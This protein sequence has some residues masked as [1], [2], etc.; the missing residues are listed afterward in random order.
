M[1]TGI[2][3]KM[4][5][6]HIDF[7]SYFA[8]AEQQKNLKLRGKPVGV[9]KAEGRTVIIA[10]SVEAKRRGVKTGMPVWE[11]KRLCPEI[12][13]APADFDSYD[14]MTRR[15]ARICRRFSD[16]VELFSLDEVFLDAT[17]TAHLFGGSWKLAL[18]LKK[19]IREELGEWMKVS[20]GIAKN[21]LL[22][23]L[24]SDMEKPDGLVEITDEN[25]DICLG[26][27]SFDQIC[28]IGRRLEERLREIGITQLLQIRLMPQ[29]CL[30][31]S[32]GPHWSKEL[33]RMAWGKDD[34]SVVPGRELGLPKSVSRTYTLRREIFD[35]EE[36]LAVVRNLVEEAAEKLRRARMAGRQFG[37]MIRGRGSSSRVSKMPPSIYSQSDVLLVTRKSYTSD[38]LTV[39][40]ELKRLFEKRRWQAPVRFLGVWISLLAEESA[41]ADCFFPEARRRKLILAAQDRINQRFGNYTLFPASLLRTKII[42][43]EVNGYLGDERIRQKMERSGS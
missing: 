12:I 40:R 23:K 24:A 25:Q 15:F 10:A 30:L 41:L 16:R 3:T 2:N 39:F 34:S 33:V 38:P 11:A 1:F 42:M 35:K 19:V 6:L 21:K 32:F 18:H 7:N 5:I 22:A 14:K 31:A 26:K 27:A 29:G 17:E 43:P 28:G 4:T 20:V 37:L 13:L 36:I 9:I 8:S